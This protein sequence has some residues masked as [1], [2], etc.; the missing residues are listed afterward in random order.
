MEIKRIYKFL[1][2]F[3]LIP[4]M[5]FGQQ[6]AAEITIP[7]FPDP[8]FKKGEG[9]VVFI[10]NGHHNF[11]TKTGRFQPFAKL[12]NRDG[13]QLRE[14]INL[15]DLDRTD[16]LVVSNPIHK[17]NIG[18]WKRPIGTAFPNA[19]IKAIKTWVSGG[20]RLLL[21]ADHMPFSGAANTLSEA[22]GF[23]FCDGFAFLNGKQRGI[24]V[25]SFE[26]QRLLDSDITNGTIGSK[27]NSI[28]SFTGSAFTIPNEAIGVMK[29][30]GEDVCLL[31]DV[32]WQFNSETESRTLENYYQGAVMVFGNGKIAVF[33]EAAMFTA[34]TI[35][36][37]NGTF[38]FG[39]HSENA[40]NN[41]QF[42]RNLMEWL[43]K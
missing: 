11:H 13:F 10:D 26:N 18:N 27:V 38:K 39:F 2:I 37:E 1:L 7:E 40:P 9:P 32:A 36:N 41:I 19:E 5:C 28:T 6:Q 25:F 20:G 3:G 21:I 31:P 16:L 33:G 35:T 12:L 24:D 14:T 4:L 29:F 15:E 17:D 22:F 34:Q 43:S 8:L 30:T 23:S 42:I